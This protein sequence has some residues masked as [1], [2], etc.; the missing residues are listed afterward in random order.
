MLVDGCPKN[1]HWK[2]LSASCE[3]FRK[4]FDPQFWAFDR[5]YQKEQK[6]TSWRVFV[7]NECFATFIPRSKHLLGRG[8]TIRYPIL[9]LDCTGRAWLESITQESRSQDPQASEE[10]NRL[11]ALLL[12]FC[13]GGLRLPANQKVAL[14]GATFLVSW[15][16]RAGFSWASPL[17]RCAGFGLIRQWYSWMRS[18][19]QKTES[20]TDLFLGTSYEVTSTK[21]NLLSPTLLATTGKI[22]FLLL[23]WAYLNLCPVVL[24]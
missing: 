5:W 19:L 20:D 23:N 15:L 3:S 21:K 24:L 17:F 16:M 2:S 8:S 11:R 14:S 13:R 6:Q 1:G 12:W 22:G 10:H 4:A 9:P 18:I 7:E